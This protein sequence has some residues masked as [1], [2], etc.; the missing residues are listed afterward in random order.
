MGVY[1]DK[2][3]NT[4]YV[5]KRYI[6]W[7][8]ENCRLFKR[9]FTTKREAQN[10]ERSYFEKLQGNLN[11]TFDDF[12]EVYFDD[13][14]QRLKLNTFLMKQNVINTKIRPYFKDFKMCEITPN[15]ILKWQNDMMKQHHKKG[16]KYTSST[17]KTMHAQL[18][19]IFNHAVKYYRL[20]KNP[21]RIVGTMGSED[22]I[23]MLFWTTE[24][25]KKFAF[26]IMD[27]PISYMAFEMLYWTGI[28]EGELLALTLED[29]DFDKCKLRINK[30]YQRLQGEDVITT[31][32]TSKS[33]RVVDIPDF[34][35]DEVKDYVA[36]LPGLKKTDRMSP[37]NKSFLYREMKRGCKAADVKKIR[38]HDLRH[39]HVSLLI[40]KGFSALAIADR[41]GH[42]SIHIT[43]KYAH[44][45]P[46][47]G[48]E[49]ANTLN[50][51]K[52]RDYDEKEF[53]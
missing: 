30:S 29:I 9:N 34:L 53:R 37:I 12:I 23:E 52:E 2:K 36:G 13:K 38:V 35:V 24:E 40:E 44:L 45:F 25:Y 6:N 47:K 18:S 32:K 10:F 5:S 26:E 43:Y 19:A 50:E 20:D 49:I 33:N 46:S 16:E 3:T 15:H 28:R 51:E 11:M 7:K 21:A 4:W 17:L 39:S 27:N 31:P 8:G 41:V 22:E 14:K 1:K 48:K 42:E